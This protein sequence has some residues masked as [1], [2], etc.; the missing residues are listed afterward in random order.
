M[1]RRRNG[2]GL[3]LAGCIGMGILS[4]AAIKRTSD[5]G[6]IIIGAG[7]SGNRINANTAPDQVA[8]AIA[9]HPDTPEITDELLAEVFNAIR[10]RAREGDLEA[11]LVL[12]RIAD[13]QRPS[14]DG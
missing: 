5:G 2:A 10:E 12:F 8:A 3:A 13:K 1:T 4:L 6:S 7:N 11:A 9:A 14:P